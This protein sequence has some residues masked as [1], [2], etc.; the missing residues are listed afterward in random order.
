MDVRLSGSLCPAPPGS[1]SNPSFFNYGV[2]T[3]EA[4]KK[5]S[6]SSDII[7]EQKKLQ[8]ADLVIFQV[9]FHSH[10]GTGSVCRPSPEMLLATVYG[11][12]RGL[13]SPL[14]MDCCL[15]FS[16]FPD[17]VVGH[18]VGAS[19]GTT[20]SRETSLLLCG[21]RLS[22]SEPPGPTPGCHISPQAGRGA[23]SFPHPPRGP[24]LGSRFCC[25]RAGSVRGPQSRHGDPDPPAAATRM[26]SALPAQPAATATPHASEQG[27]KLP[28]RAAP[29]APAR[30]G[31]G[32]GG[33]PESLAD[34][35]PSAPP[36]PPQFPL[37]WFSVPAVLKGWMDRVL[38]QG[39]AFDFPGS[40]DDGLLKVRPPPPRMR[41][42]VHQG[43]KG[44][45]SKSP[46]VCHC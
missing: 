5:R 33:T 28:T 44:P 43:R 12:Q 6:L 36:G 18:D 10:C 37:Y 41:G 38:C 14:G 23:G 19:V 31:R 15:C 17:A 25:P 39:F 9:G 42:P 7:E 27:E 8:E 34:E 4:Y 35:H 45:L 13:P 26:P 32:G 11:P 22:S 24:M 30:P 21:V 46:L 3:H 2:E 29:G 16:L 20:V 40:Y 1:L